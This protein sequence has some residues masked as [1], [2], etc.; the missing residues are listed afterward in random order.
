[1]D[2]E[3]PFDKIKKLHRSVCIKKKKST[4]V[5]SLTCTFKNGHRSS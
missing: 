2:I 3:F 5:I 1:M 4:L